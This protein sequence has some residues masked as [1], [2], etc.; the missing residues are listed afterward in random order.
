MCDE[1]ERQYGDQSIS[2]YE[3]SLATMAAYFEAEPQAIVDV[4]VAFR[5]KCGGKPKHNAS[6]AVTLRKALASAE[7]MRKKRTAAAYDEA[8]LAALIE[9]QGLLARLN[10]MKLLH[11]KVE[12]VSVARRGQHYLI[13][14]RQGRTAD[15]GTIDQMLMFRS[16]QAAISRGLHVTIDAPNRKR[17]EL[18]NPIVDAVHRLGDANAQEVYDKPEDEMREWLGLALRWLPVGQCMALTRDAIYWVNLSLSLGRDGLIR[19]GTEDLVKRPLFVVWTRGRRLLVHLPTFKL[20]ATT[21]N[22]LYR[23]LE[24]ADVVHQLANLGFR[25]NVQIT[26]QGPKDFSG[27]Q[28]ARESDALGRL[29]GGFRGGARSRHPTRMDGRADAG[30]RW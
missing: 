2:G 22:G 14:D 24:H 28:G 27:T 12:I 7:E 10:A 9:G 6:I 15:L 3:L 20:W 16:A 5:Q 29:A 18:W 1:F 26:G 25:F 21:P 23:R 17:N 13:T 11:G 30:G 19:S 8:A 4:M